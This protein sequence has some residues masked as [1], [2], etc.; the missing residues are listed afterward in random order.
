MEDHILSPNKSLAQLIII[1]SVFRETTHSTKQKQIYQ[2]LSF[3]YIYKFYQIWGFFQNT[4]KA[5]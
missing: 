1:M 3:F 4:I 5:Q 2:I